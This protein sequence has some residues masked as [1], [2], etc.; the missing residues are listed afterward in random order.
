MISDYIWS[1]TIDKQDNLWIGSSNNG[2]SKFNGTEFENYDMKD[3]LIGNNTHSITLEN[4]SEAW[5]GTFTGL[6]RL[7]PKKTN[8]T[9]QVLTDYDFLIYPNPTYNKIYIK[10][11]DILLNSKL[12][13]HTIDGKLIKLSVL[14]TNINE[15]D[16][17]N[18]ASG[19]YVV[20]IA[21]PKGIVNKKVIKL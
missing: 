16:L 4:N 11:E 9:K 6:S 13:V 10:I 17:S 3:G 5:I 19:M 7:T 21:T 2:I 18:F 8:T 1:L 12:S 14:D 15:I 20:A